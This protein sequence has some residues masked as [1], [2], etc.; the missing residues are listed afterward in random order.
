MAHSC[1][2]LRSAWTPGS[3]LNVTV[4]S[5]QSALGEGWALFALIRPRYR[6]PDRYSHA[7]YLLS[8]GGL[9]EGRPG[10]VPCCPARQYARN[11]QGGPPVFYGSRQVS[12]QPG[13][14]GETGMC[15]CIG[16]IPAD[17]RHSPYLSRG[18]VRAV[19]EI[20][21][22]Q[23]FRKFGSCAPESKPERE[24]AVRTVSN[25]V[26]VFH[27][28]L[29]MCTRERSSCA[30]NPVFRRRLEPGLSVIVLAYMVALFIGSVIIFA[31]PYRR[32]LAADECFVGLLVVVLG[33]ITPNT[34]KLPEGEIRQWIGRKV[35]TQCLPG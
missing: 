26:H 32:P 5:L 24:M 35:R 12:L 9:A 23:G 31:R 22:N 2:G 8:G 27:A 3:G 30:Q 25:R 1:P 7:H 10:V 4:S 33:V 34:V 19:N 29:Y 16:D 6:A 11:R 20:L 21:K 15:P 17:E 14:N 28:P 18:W 13:H